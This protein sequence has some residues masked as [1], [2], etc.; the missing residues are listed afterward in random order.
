MIDL[1][2]LQF[3]TVDRAFLKG[4][5]WILVFIFFASIYASPRG[6]YDRFLK[7]PEV[8]TNVLTLGNE[9]NIERDV[10]TQRMVTIENQGNDDASDLYINIHVPNGVIKRIAVRSDERYSASE[11]N[12]NAGT[13]TLEVERLAPKARIAVLLW[14]K[15]ADL[16]GSDELTATV[17]AAFD[18][19]I[20]LSEANATALAEVQGLGSSLVVGIQSMIT[21]FEDKLGVQEW[22]DA[23]GQILPLIGVYDFEGIPSSDDDFRRALTATGM[24]IFAAW[25]FLRREWAGLIMAFI[26]GIFIWLF[27]DFDMNIIWLGFA[28]AVGSIALRLTNSFR[29][30]L[31]LSVLVLIGLAVITVSTELQHWMCTN[32]FENNISYVMNCL[33]VKM[34][35]GIVLGYLAVHFY[36]IVTEL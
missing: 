8:R 5:F 4:I 22:T 30:L 34:P 19:G 36:L 10:W 1:S 27:I 16:T 28:V 18:G 2:R 25:L 13:Y 7:N 20:A 29:E 14:S 11:L 21:K 35:G 15:Q 23:A 6:V 32:P 24:I 31:I 33:P 17:S 3:P 9:V 12:L 26:V